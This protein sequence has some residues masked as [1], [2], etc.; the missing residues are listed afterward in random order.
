MLP[1]PTIIK[2]CSEC[3]GLVAE[4][5]VMS[6]NTFGATFWT[7]GKRD[8][9]MLPDQPWLVKCP[10]CQASIW[11]DEQDKAG[12]IDDSSKNEKFKDAKSYRTPK[13][14]DYFNILNIGNL[15]KKKELYLRFRAWWAGN[16]ERRETV[17]AR[18]YLS[19][20]EKANLEGLYRILDYSN[21]NDRL[22]MAELKRE[23]GEFDDAGAIMN[24]PFGNGLTQAA[25][26]IKELIEK[27]ELFVA[28]MKFEN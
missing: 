24:E 19:D 14:K 23:L 21:D 22:M 17:S 10:H 13:L 28:E 7:D 26:I 4:D 15:D 27:K 20:E 5:T 18:N 12:E 16:D 8:A 6:G 3:S 9:P 11:I 1:G 25:S 2:I